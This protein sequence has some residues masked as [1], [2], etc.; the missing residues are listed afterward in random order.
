MFAS[1]HLALR[2][3]SSEE[4]FILIPVLNHDTAF[5]TVQSSRQGNAVHNRCHY[6]FKADSHLTLPCQFRINA[7]RSLRL[8]CV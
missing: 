7:V 8:I 1:G 4:N 5:R 2:D 6:R 3:M